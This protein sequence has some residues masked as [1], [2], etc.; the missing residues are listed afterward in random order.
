MKN[1]FFKY[2]LFFIPTIIAYILTFI[3][4]KNYDTLMLN[5]GSLW[6]NIKVYYVIVFC[7]VLTFAVFKSK[8]KMIVNLLTFFF[9]LLVILFALILVDSFDNLNAHSLT[10]FVIFL[11]GAIL[12]LKKKQSRILSNNQ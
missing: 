10:V 7:L 6:V 4:F 3:I 9:L 12:F 2:Y 11:I 5:L 1:M 8:K